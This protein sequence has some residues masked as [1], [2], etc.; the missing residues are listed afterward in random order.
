MVLGTKA[1]EL[2]SSLDTSNADC[3][4]VFF[5]ALGGS[6]PGGAISSGTSIFPF[7][8]FLCSIF[9]LITGATFYMYQQQALLH[10]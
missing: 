7:L 1:E 4:P 5:A 2:S 10:P 3:L 8:N 9:S 6:S